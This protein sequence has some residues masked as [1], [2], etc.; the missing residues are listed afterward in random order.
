[1]SR[2]THSTKLKHL[3]FLNGGSTTVPSNL[4]AGLCVMWTSI[5]AR[6]C[7]MHHPSPKRARMGRCVHG[8][9]EI[10]TVSLRRWAARHPGGLQDSNQLLSSTGCVRESTWQHHRHPIF[11]QVT[12]HVPFCTCDARLR[13]GRRHF[14]GPR[15]RQVADWS[16]T[17]T[18]RDY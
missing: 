12:A 9:G 17:L 5:P 6:A 14:L 8:H 1:M 13:V 4:L 11:Q 10:R 16:E 7:M 2:Y 3:I 15:P 18:N